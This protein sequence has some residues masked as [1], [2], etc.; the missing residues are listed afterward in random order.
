M[1]KDERLKV[2]EE[3]VKN[4]SIMSGRIQAVVLEGECSPEVSVTSGVH[5]AHCWIGVCLGP[6]PLG[7]LDLDQSK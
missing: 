4:K 6:N 2:G 5:T 1:S 3:R 7:L